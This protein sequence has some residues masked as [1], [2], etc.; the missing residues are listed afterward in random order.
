MT[1]PQHLASLAALRRARVDFLLVGALALGHYAPEMAS[2]YMT[3][4]C[5]ILVRPIDVLTDAIGND[6]AS[7]WGSRTYF[8]AGGARIPCAGLEQIIRSK[9]AAGR[10]KDK[11]ILSLYRTLLKNPPK[12]HG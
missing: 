8:R 3:A 4:D 12:K 1:P 2:F 10:E 7:W 5:D 9:M 6:F 11:K